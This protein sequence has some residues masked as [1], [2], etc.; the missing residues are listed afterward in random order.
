MFLDALESPVHAPSSITE[1]ML[2]QILHAV[3][4]RNRKVL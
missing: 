2:D 4:E 1:V 3:S